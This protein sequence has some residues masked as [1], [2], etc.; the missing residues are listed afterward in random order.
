MVLSLSRAADNSA[1][2]GKARSKH[3]GSVLDCPVSVKRAEFCSGKHAG[4]S[5]SARAI[6]ATVCVRMDIDGFRVF[7]GGQI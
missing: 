2:S 7:R 4:V 1:F 5:K 3:L 6:R